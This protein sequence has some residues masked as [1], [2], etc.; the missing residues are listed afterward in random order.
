MTFD[1]IERKH[2]EETYHKPYDEVRKIARENPL[3]RRA[4]A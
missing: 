3:G 1:E 2:I 4:T